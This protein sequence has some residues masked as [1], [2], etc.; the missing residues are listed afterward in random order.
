MTESFRLL[1]LE[2]DY[3][4]TSRGHTADAQKK[5]GALLAVL[6]KGSNAKRGLEDRILTT[7]ARAVIESHFNYWLTVI[8]SA[9]T[10]NDPQQENAY[11]LIPTA[12]RRAGVSPGIR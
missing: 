3:M 4:W 11:I 7:T 2:S 1:G 5:L 8:G 6:K 10:E 12:R 9:A